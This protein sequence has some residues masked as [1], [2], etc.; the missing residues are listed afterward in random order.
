[1]LTFNEELHQYQYN[2][3]VKPSVT[4]VLSRLH[5]FGMVPVDVLEAACQRGS[6]VHKLTEYHDEGDLD[7]SSVGTYRGYLDA[8]IKF[9]ADHKAVWTG[10]EAQCY[11]ERF[12]FAG[13][14]DRRGHLANV[15]Y[16]ID[17]KTSLQPHK[18]WGMQT[19]AYRQLSA[20]EDSLWMLARRATVQLRPDGTY[21][22]IPWDSPQ[23]WPAFQALITLSNW[24]NS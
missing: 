15:P 19:A 11:S 13:T 1:M 3:V 9:C 8:W 4:A 2:G 6:Y 24:S 17:I 14:M 18:V 5:D 21:K 12:G 10:I 20:E 23:D 7:D 22:F 16:I